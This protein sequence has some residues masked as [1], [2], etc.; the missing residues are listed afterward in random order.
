MKNKLLIVLVLFVSGLLGFLF[1]LYHHS[2]SVIPPIELPADSQVIQT[3]HYPA[4]FVKQLQG[5]PDAGRKIF[6]EFC[7]ACHAEDPQIDIRAPHIGDKK[8]WGGLRQLGVP[9]L[10][11]ITINGAGAMPA[12]GGCFEC[13]D[14]QLEM[15]IRYILDQS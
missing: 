3:F 7:A 13:S 15:A 10:L 1:S 12:R 8:I 2:E 14:D 6:K 5:D 9:A 11:K 4:I